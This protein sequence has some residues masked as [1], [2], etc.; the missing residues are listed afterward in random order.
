MS[1]AV[2]PITRNPLNLPAGS[3][4]GILA[5]AIAGLFAILIALP[6]DRDI[7]IPMFLYP[8]LSLLLV[9]SVAHGRSIGTQADRHPL[10]LPRGML[11]LLIVAAIVATVT[12]KA[13]TERDVLLQRLTPKPGQLGE[14]PA[15]LAALGGGFIAGRMLRLGP[16]RN[17]PMFQDLL[18]WVALLCMIGLAVETL[19]VVFVHPSLP[20]GL[21]LR[22]LELCLTGAVAL[23][24]GARS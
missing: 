9:Y 15:L 13:V 16:W 6:A 10:G 17:T 22:A 1:N 5:L 4:R 8:L 21:N 2:Q 18:A 14:W 11:R 20:D 24:F 19:G 7:V 3:V 23:Y 12:W